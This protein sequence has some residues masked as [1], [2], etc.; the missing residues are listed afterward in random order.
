[1]YL[2]YDDIKQIKVHPL[3]LVLELY[4]EMLSSSFQIKKAIMLHFDT[5]QSFV[6]QTL[7]EDY[8]ELRQ[9]I[10]E[11]GQYIV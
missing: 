10:Q 3:S 4:P 7:I 8:K 11:E 5:G 6:I 2:N 1:V 9:N